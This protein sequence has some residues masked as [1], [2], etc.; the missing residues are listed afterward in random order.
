[1]IGELKRRWKHHMVVRNVPS[2]LWDYGLRYE[3]EIMSRTARGPEGRTGIERITGD[4]VDISEWLDFKF[5]DVVWYWH[6]E[7]PTSE[8]NPRIGR[9]LGVSHRVIA[10][11]CYWIITS[12]AQVLSRTTVQHVPYIDQKSLDI[13]QKITAFDESLRA[14]LSDMGY[15]DDSGAFDY[16]QETDI[17]NDEVEEPMAAQQDDYT[18]DAYDQYLGAELITTYFGDFRYACVTKRKYNEI[19]DPIGTRNDDPRLDTR[20]YEVVMDDG[21]VAE[22]TA[23]MIAEN[24]YSQVDE[25]GKRYLVFKEIVDHQCDRNA[26]LHGHNDKPRRTTKGWHL[27][28]EWRDGS[29]SWLTLDELRTS[30][31]VELAEYAFTNQ[32]IEEPAFNWWAKKVLRRC[33]HIISKLKSRYWKTTHK[34]GIALPHSVQEALNIDYWSKSTL[35]RQAID[36]EMKN[37]RPAFETWDGTIDQAISGKF[38]VGYQRIRCHMIFDIKMD[39][40][41]RK[42]R[43]VAGG[44]MTETP[45]SI[46]YSSVVSRESVRIAFLLAALNNLDI[47]VA[48]VGNAYLNADCKEKIWTVAGPEFGSNEG[49]VMLIKKALYGLKS[50]GA[51]WRELFASSLVELDFK[52]TYADPDLWIRLAIDGNDKYYEMILVYVDD[53][54]CISRDTKS[55]MDHLASKYRLKE[56][57]VKQPEKYL[58]ANIGKWTLDDGRCVWSMSAK[59]YINSAVSNVENRLKNDGPYARTLR[60]HAYQ[61]FKT[62]YRPEIDVTPILDDSMASYYQ[63]LIGVLR[64]ICEL[65]RIDI[66]TE[67]TMLSSHNALPQQGHLEAVFD[68]FAY[69]KRHPSAAIVFD[70]ALPHVQESRFKKVDC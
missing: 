13:R 38:L 51:A 6:G 40:L 23:N 44:H 39:D 64:W 9:W 7:D 17:T 68:I 15:V 49:K 52:N 2:R 8:E 67:V 27:E 18:P 30:N 54:L 19:G 1:M 65:G 25:E 70:D 45:T 55:I 24:L 57:S 58:G 22:Y 69:L 66:L 41:I 4:S 47:L 35:W 42:A 28:V 50:S 16:I 43:F 33:N 11:M 14:K 48:D 60:P 20:M 37:V 56:G 12:K 46:T 29:T 31:P 62:K 26:V 5:Y 36:K 59:S 32:I 21:A 3:A 61:P 10:K 63:G 34:F 53:I